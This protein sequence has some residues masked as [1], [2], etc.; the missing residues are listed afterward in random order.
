MDV[1]G[2]VLGRGGRRG[3]REGGGEGGREG[4]RKE[5]DS[6]N[7][8]LKHKQAVNILFPFVFNRLFTVD[9][10]MFIVNKLSLVPY[11]DEN[12]TF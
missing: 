8:Q 6:C 7:L 11:G 2:G 4:G 3:G 5:K 10:E 12:R 9:R 1:H